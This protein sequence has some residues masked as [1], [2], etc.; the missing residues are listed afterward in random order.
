MP[1][2]KNTK[3]LFI[4]S[5]L[6]P[7]VLKAQDVTNDYVL[8]EAS[9]KS[10]IEN[11]PPTVSQLEASFLEYKRK[12]LA[13]KDAFSLSF[14]GEG[15]VYKSNERLLNNFDAVTQNATNYT[16]GVVRPTS[17]GVDLSV[18]AFGEKITNAFV[19]GAS[20]NGVVLGLSIDLYQNFLGRK[21]NWTLK[22]A[23]ANLKK[24]KLEKQVELKAFESNLRK[25]YWSLVANEEKKILVES[26][27]QTAE[28]QLSDAL[29]RRRSGVADDGE[30][31]RFRSQL[32]SRKANLTSLA[33]E[34]SEIAKNLREL[35]PELASKNIVIDKY[36][37]AQT[38]AK[39]F[40]CI[41][42]INSQSS[43]PLDYS[44][45]DDI[46][47]L[48]IEDNKYEQKIIESYNSLD[49][50][51]NGEYSNVG[52]DFSYE[53]ARQDFADDPRARTN[54]S[55]K[56]SMPLDGKKTR[57][58]EITQQANKSR[59]LSLAQGQ[60]AKINAFHTE[61]IQIISALKDIL[62]SQKE[63]SQYLGQSLSESRKKFNQGRISLQELISEQDAQVQ[64]KLNEIDSNL[65]IVKTII[66]YFSIYT[67]TP[68]EF[69]RI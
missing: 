44:L 61:T 50:K 36:D 6:L 42:L 46:V 33:Y 12:D 55:L 64:N 3:L 14:E 37:V 23:D 38:T 30:I 48:L 52:R 66:D 21:S 17:M 4:M 16:F 65:I 57:T 11:S 60:L 9:F 13:T 67:T 19:S 7:L 35:L 69:N 10:L 58:K 51:L 27:I 24:A 32:S 45:Y 15:R 18:K 40:E 54:L 22:Q 47:E 59:T 8:S 41:G 31:A 25:M 62:K 5:L 49:I 1:N 28:K 63:T 68:C 2:L 20:T 56:I 39:V 53:G 34:K 26:L 29:A 43:S